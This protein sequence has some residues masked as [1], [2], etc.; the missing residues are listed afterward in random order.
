MQKITVIGIATIKVEIRSGGVNKPA[1]K[2]I[3]AK[4]VNS[5]LIIFCVL[6]FSFFDKTNPKIAITTKN[7]I[8]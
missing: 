5:T 1:N 3:Q 7:T 6:G 2:K 8:T 4:P